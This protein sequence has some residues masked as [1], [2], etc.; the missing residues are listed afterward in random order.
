MAFCT[1]CGKEVLESAVV[2]VGCG[3]PVG[4]KLLL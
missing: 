1:A 2:C 4:K 3:S